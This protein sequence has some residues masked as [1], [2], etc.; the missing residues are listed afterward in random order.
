MALEYHQQ[1]PNICVNL[2]TEYPEVVLCVGKICFGEKARKKMPKNSKQ[3]QKYT[4]VCAVCALLNSGGGVVKAEIENENYKLEGDTIGLDL[5]ETFRS[6]LLFPD[7]REYLD[8]EQRDN[9]ILIFI[10][11]WSSENTSLT[12][13][14]AKPRLCS[15]TTGLHTKCGTS[16]SRVNLIQVVSFLKRKQDKAKKELSPGPPAKTRK[17]RA[18]EGGTDIINKAVVELF[19]RDQLQHGETLTFSE[20]G[21]VEFKH[22]STEKILTR[23]KEIL[24]QYIAGFANT[25]GGY[26]W[27]GVDDKGTVQGFSSDEEDLKKLSYIINSIKDK[28]TLFHF[29][30]SG[31]EHNISYEHKIFKVYHE[32]GDHCGYVCAVKIQPFTCVAFSE[33]PDS[34]LVE[35][36]TVKR[37]SACEWATWMTTADPDLSKFSETFRLEL[38]LTERPPLAKPVYS[39]QGLDNIDDL[40]K[41]LFPVESHRIIYT[42]EKLSEDLLQE[43]PGLDILMEKQ[44]KQLSEGVLIFSRSWAVEVGLPE[45]PDIICDILLIAEDRPPILYTICKH[46]ISPTLLEYSRCIAWRLKQ[47]LVNTGGYIHKLC[48]IPKLLILLPEINCGKEWD[49]NIQ[50]MYPQNYSLIRS[51]NLKALLRALTVVLLSFKSFLSD[52]V[53]SEFLNLLTIKQYQLLSENL[54]KTKKLYVYGLPGTGKTIVAL[55]IIE[56]IRTML[57]CKQEE[58]LYVCENKPLRDFVRQKNICQAVTRVA[59]LKDS[60]NYVKHIIIDE[61]QNFQDGGGDWYK[62]ALALTSSADLP[63]PGFFWIFLDYLQTSHCFPTGLPEAEW[64]D[65][66]ESLTKVVR[67]ASNIYS[68]LKKN[69]ETIVMHSTLNIP[70]DRLRELLCRAT[71]AP[72]VQGSTEVQSK[73]NIYEIAKYVAEHCHTYLKKGY[74]KK[75][76]AVLCYRD[77]EVKAHRR[78][79]ASEM[80]KSNILLRNT[81]EGL[82]EH[83]IL[84]S[85]RRFSGLERSI[86][87][88]IIPQHFQ[89][90]EKIFENILVCV[91]SRANLNLHLLFYN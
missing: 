55:K 26:L 50:E 21:N 45:N 76:I 2:V 64:H 11:T 41:Q 81:E 8:F 67:N 7:W 18:V 75:D 10:K 69:M 77:D 70:K 4:L 6:L 53:G 38:S 42:P 23:V 28:L 63:K 84:D 90:Q 62:K 39:H 15:L 12:S 59:F 48:V 49:L 82:Q 52:H 13:T 25:S 3:D 80:R 37:L 85:I 47:K 29:C 19:N 27:I 36:S 51:D 83:A 24:P 32:A 72:A 78:I 35:G 61:A 44:L 14:S 56:K 20:S 86:V 79:L 16:L 74:S 43:H 22:Y 91:A 73:Q 1:Q 71:C 30:G 58:V 60:F 57:Q 87:F 46:H 54:H 34:W 17:T 68:Y 89:F 5:E 31:C 40:C 88:G 66:I 33:D 9:Y 65:P